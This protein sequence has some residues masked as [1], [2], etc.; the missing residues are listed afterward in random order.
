MAMEE[1]KEKE[2]EAQKEMEMEE[3]MKM[4][5]EMEMEVKEDMEMEER[6][7]GDGGG[8]RLEGG[9]GRR[10]NWWKLFGV[11]G[12]RKDGIHLERLKEEK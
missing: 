5:E 6:S 9:I 4:E 11:R 10:P 8:L 12:G 7:D 2:M 1:E 3:E